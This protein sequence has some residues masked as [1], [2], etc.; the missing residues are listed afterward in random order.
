MIALKQAFIAFSRPRLQ[1]PSRKV[2]IFL[3]VVMYAAY[4]M[5]ITNDMSKGSGLIGLNGIKRLFVMDFMN[6]KS[7]FRG[8]RSLVFEIFEKNS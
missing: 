2:S 7:K 1:E 4:G 8:K 3:R 5:L 6:Q